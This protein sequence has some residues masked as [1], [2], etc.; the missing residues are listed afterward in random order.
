VVENE[1]KGAGVITFVYVKDIDGNII[2]LQSW[3]V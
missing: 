3:K 1:I 2:E